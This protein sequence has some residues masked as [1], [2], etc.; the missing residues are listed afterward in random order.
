MTA[1][2]LDRLVVRL[3]GDASHYTGVMDDA[4]QTAQTVTAKITRHVT[5]MCAKAQ[6]GLNALGNTA[7]QVGSMLSVGITLPVV[8]A[9]AGFVKMASDAEETASKFGVVF[10]SVAEEAQAMAKHLDE[11]YGMSG[12]EARKLLSDTGDLLSG[13]GFGQREALEMSN[14]VQQFAVDLASFQNVDPLRASEALTKGLLGE[15]EMMKSLGI[16]ILEEDVKKQVLLNTTNGLTFATERQAKAYATL[17]LAQQQSKNAIGD[18]AR[19][20]DSFANQMRE[21]K[22]DLVDV[23]VAFGKV[24]LPYAKMGL[25]YVRKGI[26]W[27]K[28]LSDE[29]RGWIVA[30]SAIAAAAG[31]VLIALG[32]LA[33][34]AAGA[35]GGLA[36]IGSMASTLAP[37]VAVVAAIGAAVAAVTAAAAGLAYWLL[38]PEGIA[39]AWNT[40]TSTVGTWY[41]NTMGFLANFQHNMKALFAWLPNNWGNV[42]EDMMRLMITWAMNS[43]HNTITM[44][45]TLVRV[46]VAWHGYLSSIFKQVF[47]VDFIKYIIEGI[48]KATMKFMAFANRTQEWMAAAFSGE[49]IDVGGFFDQLEKDFTAGANSTDIFGTLKGILKEGMADLNNP[50]KGFEST[51]KEGPDFKFDRAVTKPLDA[52]AKAAGVDPAAPPALAAAEASIAHI[53]EMAAEPIKVNIRVG[54]LDALLAGSAEAEQ[55]MQDYMALRAVEVKAFDP[56]AAGV[57]AVPAAERAGGGHG[58]V[59]G[60]PPDTKQTNKR[61]EEVLSKIEEN[62]R[63]KSSLLLDD[64]VIKVETIDL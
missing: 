3:M 4:V 24:L 9:G 44:V 28:N 55:A 12:H 14:A 16:A 37:V 22:A 48:K 5:A 50:L 46:W 6:A 33:T 49:S 21:V 35:A 41:E 27:F 42:L 34:L 45:K 58:P 54:G 43:V 51:I 39:E 57:A 38:G 13:F 59:G 25:E 15:R 56:A 29:T 32:T 30:I 36:T 17:Q 19:T 31:P 20:Q 23:G 1:T 47:T 7:K 11:A 26:D 53:K 40:A 2:E 8:A 63:P 62:T 64:S 10:S 52:A 18:Y 61:M 60:L